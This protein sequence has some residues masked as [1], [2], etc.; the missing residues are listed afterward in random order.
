M[1]HEKVYNNPMKNKVDNKP[2][3]RLYGTPA[4]RLKLENEL[5][6]MPE[7]YTPQ[8][9]L[10]DDT[11]KFNTLEWLSRWGEGYLANDSCSPRGMASIR[12]KRGLFKNGK[13]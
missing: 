13:T 7:S 4:L 9:P 11:V 10:N 12:S 5:A 6:I 3:S 1:C 2:V 8:W